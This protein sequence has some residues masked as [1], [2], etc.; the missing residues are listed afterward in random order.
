[1]DIFKT[2]IDLKDMIDFQ[3]WFIYQEFEFAGT[4]NATQSLYF[5]SLIEHGF[6]YILNQISAKWVNRIASD[7]PG[8]EPAIEFIDTKRIIA[9]GRDIIDEHRRI[10]TAYQSRQLRAVARNDFFGYEGL[11]QRS[12]FVSVQIVAN[13]N[14][15]LHF[16]VIHIQQFPDFLGPIDHR[17]G[18][19][20]I[21]LPP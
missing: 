14:H 12:N 16:R 10:L 21:H 5:S 17:F 15:F 20:D 1:M 6:T 2:K 9:L 13:E 7:F 4:P 18:L 19:A 3:P 8:G 11:V